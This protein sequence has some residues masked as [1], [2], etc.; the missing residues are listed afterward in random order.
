[1]ATLAGT[2]L[3]AG[4]CFRLSA[5]DEKQGVAISKLSV[6][7]PWRVG[8]TQTWRRDFLLLSPGLSIYLLFYLDCKTTNTNKGEGSLN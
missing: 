8:R 2:F 5:Q 6:G 7:C 4:N 1:M 3:A